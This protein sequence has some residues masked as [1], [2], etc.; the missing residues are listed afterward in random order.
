MATASDSAANALKSCKLI[1]ETLDE[2]TPRQRLHLRCSM[3]K[4][5]HLEKCIRACIRDVYDDI[6]QFCEAYLT[7]SRNHGLHGSQGGKLKI[8]LEALRSRD[9]LQKVTK[10][11]EMQSHVR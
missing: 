1:M 5:C 6:L 10:P 11:L 7:C 2:I 4:V 8:Y 3:H 9:G